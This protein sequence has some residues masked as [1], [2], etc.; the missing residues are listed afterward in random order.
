[1][2]DQRTDREG[3]GLKSPETPTSNAS[4]RVAARSLVVFFTAFA[5]LCTAGTFFVRTYWEALVVVPCLIAMAG[6]GAVWIGTILHRDT[7]ALREN[8]WRFSLKA[9]FVLTTATALILGFIALSKN[10]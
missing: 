4:G 8:G 6:A 7:K 3:G 10:Y 9:L 5:F 1:M 2:D